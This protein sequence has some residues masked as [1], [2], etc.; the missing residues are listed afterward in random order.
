M[1]KTEIGFIFDISHE[2]YGEKIYEQNGYKYYENDE[3][4][5]E[6]EW[7]ELVSN[8][9]VI[10]VLPIFKVNRQTRYNYATYN[11]R[12]IKET[13][14]LKVTSTISFVLIVFLGIYLLYNILVI[15]S[16][17][18]ITGA[19]NQQQEIVQTI[20]NTQLQEINENNN[21]TITKILGE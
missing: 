13:A 9:Q 5:E 12:L 19:L 17:K 16:M 4:L 8:G 11:D 3:I 2:K 15:P 14:R 20:D 7:E 1:N 18:T 10:K 21:Q 6:K